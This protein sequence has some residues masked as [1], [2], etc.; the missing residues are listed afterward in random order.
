MWEMP[1]HGL[2]CGEYVLQGGGYLLSS[3]GESHPQTT[4]NMPDSEYVAHIQTTTY[5]NRM[6]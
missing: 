1:A 6:F 3:D 4:Y 5:T 2:R